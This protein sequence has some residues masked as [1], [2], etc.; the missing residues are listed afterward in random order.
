VAIITLR[1]RGVENEVEVEFRA[2]DLEQ[3]GAQKD[4]GGVASKPLSTT[5]AVGRR[6]AKR[7]R[8]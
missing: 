8:P 4:A 6:S 5:L 1:V 7:H 3:G 2:D